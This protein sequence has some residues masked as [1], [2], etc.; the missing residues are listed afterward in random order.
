MLIEGRGLDPHVQGIHSPHLVSRLDWR[1]RVV[2]VDVSQFT[3][4]LLQLCLQWPGATQVKRDWLV[5]E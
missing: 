4:L 2:E 3:C 1:D 5:G